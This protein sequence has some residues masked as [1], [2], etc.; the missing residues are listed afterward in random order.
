M[1]D[2]LITHGMCCFVTIH[3][4]TNKTRSS[5]KNINLVVAQ[6]ITCNRD[7]ICILQN[8]PVFILH[9]VIYVKI[10]TYGLQKTKIKTLLEL[11][12]A[13]WKILKLKD[14]IE[15][16]EK[17]AKNGRRYII[18]Y[19]AYVYFTAVG[20][21]IATLMPQFFDLIKPL[22]QS[23][24]VILLYPAEYFVD[25]NNNFTYIFMHMTIALQFALLVLIAADSMFICYTEYANGLFAIIG[26]RFQY[27]LYKYSTGNILCQN[28][29]LYKSNNIYQETLVDTI[30]MHLR[31]INFVKLLESTYTVP[32]AITLGLNTII[33]SCT[34]LQIVL[35]SEQTEE[36]VKYLV[37]VFAQIFHLFCISFQGQKIIDGSIRVTDKIYNGLWYMM[38]AK[39]QKNLLI[40]LRRCLEPCRLSAGKIYVFS[41]RS[42]TTVMQT[43]MSYFTVLSSFQ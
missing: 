29:T 43:S 18:F 34:L 10:Y 38:P 33:M 11:M 41:L 16:M 13:E 25:V 12:F 15:I 31:A 35:V 26:Y 20:C 39:S 24:P 23:R 4:R 27:L 22:N 6:F 42:F 37:Y 8:T 14:E 9:S 5:K 30:Q 36:V 19:A 1:A 28:L 40:P 32:F 3:K 7:V 21:V 2:T 17:Y